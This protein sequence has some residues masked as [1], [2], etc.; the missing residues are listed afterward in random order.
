MKYAVLLLAVCLSS[1]N[2]YACNGEAQIIAKVSKV[3]S[4]NNMCL[5]SIHPYTI[6]FFASSG[7]CPLDEQTIIQQGILLPANENGS[8]DI[9]V[10]QDI[11]GVVVM[12]EN[13]QLGLE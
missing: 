11:S 4:S 5:V 9:Q 10:D 1:L 13:G 8:C 7:V 2:S 12:K 3:Q 6:R